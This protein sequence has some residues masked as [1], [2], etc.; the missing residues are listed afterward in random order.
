MWTAVERPESEVSKLKEL[1]TKKTQVE[2]HSNPPE[3]PR[4]ASPSNMDRDHIW[5]YKLRPLMQ[6]RWYPLSNVEQLNVL[7]FEK[8]HNRYGIEECYS[9]GDDE[10]CNGGQNF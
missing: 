9:L 7:P 8:L 4:V 2:D 6:P 1:V 10:K 5:E 3:T